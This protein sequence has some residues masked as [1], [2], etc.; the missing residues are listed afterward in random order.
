MVAGLLTA[1]E[2]QEMEQSGTCD[3]SGRQLTELPIEITRLTTLQNLLLSGN[4]LTTLPP[5]IV[6]LANLKTLRLDRNQL[7]VLPPE[8]TQLA[9]LQD[10][11][12]IGNR[13]TALT[14]EIAR[15]NDLQKLRLDDNGLTELPPEIALLN[16]LRI[17]WLIG[18]GLTE[19]PPEIVQ[20]A[21]LQDLRLDDNGFT[22][23]PIEITQLVNLEILWLDDNGLTALPSEIAQLMNLR[24]LTL[25]DNHLTALP[26]EIAQLTSLRRLLLNS[27]G[28]TVLPP[29]VTGLT[30]LR[31][32][33]LDR[34]GL[35]SLPPEIGRLTSLETL[36]LSDN[37]L[38]ALPTDVARLTGLRD[39]RLGGNQLTVLPPEV[40]GLTG[41]RE[42]RL[43]R[44]ALTSLPPEIGR[45]SSLR[46]LTLSANQVS[47]LPPGISRLASLETLTL[48]DNQLVALPLE[49]ADQLDNGL[50]LELEDNPLAEPLPEL[51]K[52]GP[53]AV[54]VYLRSLPDGIPQYEAKVLLIGEGNVGKTSLSAAL[55]GE[56]FVKGRPLTHGIEI[57]P[58]LLPYPDS[59]QQMTIRMWD[60]GG[61]EVYRITHQFFFSQRALY[62][63]VWRPR[64]GQE[65]N[66][67]EGWLRRIRL[68]VGSAARVMIVATHSEAE[69]PELDY[70][71]LQREFPD[72][73]AGHFEVDNQTGYG[74]KELR[75]AIAAHA[76]HLPQMGEKISSRWVAVRDEIADLALSH[77]QIS[78][79]DFTG[80]C[81]RHQLSE[82]ETSTL[83]VLMHDLGQII[84][85]G[86]D[87]GLQDF[88]ILNPEW[89]TKAISYVLR[90]EPT[91]KAGGVLE[92][93][94]LRQIWQDPQ[95]GAGYPTR[96]HRYFLRLMEKF[97]ISYR[98][99]DE[100][101]SLVAQLVPYDRPGL[102]WDADT[103]LL[104]KVHRLALVCRLSEPA[105]GLMAWLTVR[106]HHATT[107]RHWRT[108]VFLRHP[109]S[110]YAS[111]ALLELRAPSQ[112]V[113]EVRAPSPDHYFHVLSESIETLIK[114][115]WPGL[116]YELFIPCPS[117][118]PEGTRCPSLLPME[119]LLA[120]REEG[121]TRF[122]CARCRARHDVTALL[123]GFPGSSQPLAADIVREQLDRVEGHV[124]R[125]EDKLADTAAVIRRVLRVVSTEITDCPTLFTLT[126]DQQGGNKIQR[127]YRHHYWLTLWCAHPDHWHPW[128]D[129]AYAIDPPKEWFVKIRPYAQ[130][131]VRTLQLLVP[132][133]GSIAVASLP[134]E[135]IERASAHLE[136]MKTIVDAIPG[137]SGEDLVPII[138]GAVAAQLTLAEGD[139]LRAL[140]ALL[141]EHDPLR[142]FGGLR[143]V[144][145]PSGDFLWVCPIHYT[146]YDPGLP[147]VP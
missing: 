13:L 89:L 5:E 44:N 51:I 76:L 102:P 3:L 93:A 12:L 115:R 16:N 109:I 136:M 52:Q 23:L 122:L 68:R 33:R 54:A 97:D 41:L 135:Q 19:L 49:I 71:Y 132:L 112:L 94:H 104:S 11:N 7:T 17:L 43:D 90:D 83:A 69:H 125:I 81:Q 39:L 42:L 118:T 50:L 70:P 127:L 100:Q 133:A 55:R 30:G 63:V 6:D 144:Q 134:T 130:L 129:A 28:L 18:N 119:S 20:L 87:D 29:E 64:E 98:L 85:Y 128:D 21:N 67:V 141:F 110:A 124:V 32:L 40:T 25:S 65:Q 60:F 48:S 140:R 143:R 26:S 86:V 22:E 92:H 101:R 77:P 131:I 114:S 37:Q 78:F 47:V 58:M 91:R 145:N 61:Q 113:L 10:L 99:E 74:I 27:N 45:L 2:L 79:E 96:Y 139:A 126:Q 66:E 38:T 137:E 106:H 82:E 4:G 138:P 121:E 62:L 73:L 105:P 117:V 95:E 88:V 46:T 72:M 142:R 15:L 146:Q 9:K 111:E 36:T 108:G 116:A 120:Y 59:P 8:I 1:E 103:P 34:N 107:G 53:D 147:A 75:D 57:R 56:S 31:E 35:T 24:D 14:P 80:V 123:T 84:Y